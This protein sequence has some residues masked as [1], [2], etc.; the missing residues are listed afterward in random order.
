MRVSEF[1]VRR[2][3][4][5]IRKSM[6]PTK[7]RSI[8]AMA[9]QKDCCLLSTLTRDVVRPFIM[10]SSASTGPCILLGTGLSTLLA[11]LAAKALVACQ[12]QVTAI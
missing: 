8:R 1:G 7:N 2:R 5:T 10:P 4:H 6:K 3:I 12:A 9:T 11:A